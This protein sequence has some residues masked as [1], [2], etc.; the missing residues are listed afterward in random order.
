[1]AGGGSGGHITP[2]LPLAHALRRR[3]PQCRLIYIG[4]RGD[5]LEGIKERFGVF[6]KV[7]FVTSGK[8]RRYHGQSFLARL[9]DIK[10][11]F[12]NI[13]DFFK[14][15]YGT[16][17]ARRL[18]KKLKP[19]VVFSKGGYVVV[20][21]G[22]AAR[23][24]HIPIITHDS[25]AEPGLAN[26]LVG[27][28]A[29]L[30]TTGMPVEYYAGTYPADTVKY[31][32]VPVDERIQPVTPQLQTDYKKQ[33]NIPADSFVLLVSG[34]GLGSATLNDKTLAIAA[35]FLSQ[36]SKNYILHFTGRTHEAMVQQKYQQ[37]LNDEQLE[38]VKVAGFNDQFYKYSGA[39]DLVVTRAGASTLAELALQ[40]K[41]CIIMPAAFLTGG[42]Q[43]KNAEELKKYHA[44]IVENDNLKPQNLLR[45]IEGLRLNS[46][47]RRE[48]A[49]NLGSMARP[50]AADQ[51][52]DLILG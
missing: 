23:R 50:A 42:H 47:R 49:D 37:I 2:L 31:V 27:R 14:V 6:D 18:L 1:M 52:A 36:D 40:A 45:L 33:L 26:R 7:F 19:N 15:L 8:L 11:I 44:A 30:H 51:L 5:K 43:S 34:G 10:T 24:L 16:V 25:D 9:V 32:G 41:A 28:W 13:R 39:A 35:E 17:S 12:L 38:R 22:L 20:P 48:L 46:K 4:L 29:R 21:I 3:Q